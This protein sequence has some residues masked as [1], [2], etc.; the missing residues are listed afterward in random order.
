MIEVDYLVVGSGAT[1]LAFADT[2]VAEADVEVALV[3]RR[4]VPGGHWQDA[5]P[6]VRLHT[7]SAFYGC[8]SLPLGADRIDSHGDNA[9]FYERASGADVNA[10]F[11]EVASRLARTG[12]VRLLGE[13]EHIDGGGNRPELVRRL[14]TGTFEEVVVNRRVVDARYLEASIPATHKRPFQVTQ[15]A[16]VV[17]INALPKFA[18][19]SA[20]FTVLGSGKTA[21]DAC[22]WLLDNGIEPGRLRWVRPRDAWFEDRARFQPLDLVGRTM[23][24]ISLDAE[25]AANATDLADLFDRLEASGRLSRIDPKRPATIYRGTVLSANELDHL[26]RIEDVIRL[27]HVRRVEPDRLVLERGEA[28]TAPDTLHVDCTA[29]GLAKAPAVPIFQP[30][31]I[32]LQQVR[33]NSPCFN[34]ALIA[35]IEAHRDEDA[36]RNRLCPPNPYAGRTG[37]WPRMMSR[38]WRTEG[39]W[40]DQPDLI[41]WLSRTR[42]NILG[43]LPGHAGESL[44]TAAIKRYLT[45]LEPALERLTRGDFR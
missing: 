3:D 9:G 11:L 1:G 20:G 6:F 43:A 22:M 17:P 39:R 45:N 4:S 36:D 16:R 10:Y 29:R 27:G 13:H 12:R 2:L 5:Y 32:V 15:N 38:T 28:T 21:V 44:V 18:E 26:R 41:A 8:D 34:A 31:R 24:G 33:H 14:R 7:P 42:L 37:D 25:A 35:F 40:L 19:S 23:E 30:G